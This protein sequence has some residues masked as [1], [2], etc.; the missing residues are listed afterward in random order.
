MNAFTIQVKAVKKIVDFAAASGVRAEDLYEAVEFDPRLLNDPDNRIPFRLVVN[1]YEK[2]AQLSGDD[3]FGL[4]VGLSAKLNAFD[5]LGY[6]VLNSATLG[7]ACARAVR[8]HSIWTDGAAFELDS[9]KQFV[10]L[11]YN[12]LDGS[13][14]SHRQDTEMTLAMV[15]ALCLN[16]T[17]GKWSA[18]KI[19]FT[20]REPRDT[21]EH[22]QLFRCPITYEAPTNSLYF[23]TDYLSLP[24][25]QADPVLCSVLDRH[26]ENLLSRFPPRNSIVDQSRSIIGHE[27]RGGDPSLERVAAQL[28]LSARTLQRKLHEQHTSHNELV[29]HLRHE[30]AVRYLQEREMAIG[31]VAYLLGF[32]EPSSFH[33]AFKR[34][35]GATPREFRD[36]S[37]HL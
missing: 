27:L 26:A 11:T 23:A 19:H 12:Y 14:T 8:Y 35:T 13:I 3:N 15:A 5:V 37:L 1:L 16:L 31:E 30:L 2:A 18:I 29:D 10:T 34:W 9:T 17:E 20:H 36:K 25:A 22:R 32:S 33:R 24:M 6:A 28:G 4:H 21:T 7:E